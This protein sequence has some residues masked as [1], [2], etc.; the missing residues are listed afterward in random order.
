M[1][2]DPSNPVTKLN[3]AALR[4]NVAAY[5]NIQTQGYNTAADSGGG[6]YYLNTTDTTSGDNGGTII[7]DAAGHRYYRVLTGSIS[8]LAFTTATVLTNANLGQLIG[9]AGA[10]SYANTLP[11][12]TTC[13]P[14]STLAL[15]SSVAGVIFNVTSPDVIHPCTPAT[16]TSITLNVG[17]TAML[18]VTAA[19]IWQLVG[20][21]VQLPFTGV[22]NG[23]APLNSPHF[24]GIPTAPTAAPGDTTTQIAT[25]A[26]VA[27]SFAPIAS[28]TLTGIPRAP[29]ASQG[30]TTTQIATTAFVTTSPQFLG[31]PT[32]PTAAV[33]TQTTQLATTAFAN[34]GSSLGASG[35]QIFPSGMIIQWGIVPSGSAR[36][37]TFPMTFPNAAYSITSGNNATIT[38]NAV[39]FNNLTTTGVDVTSTIEN[40]YFMVIGS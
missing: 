5:Q 37:I 27:A 10:G 20:G 38:S 33:G 31:T 22:F 29:T 6:F 40:D 1:A 14:G 35:Y 7:V 17:D 15:F 12:T 28:P 30:T 24:T 23:F 8:Q 19:G 34:P 4:A 32:A 11:L 2:F 9:F 3:I 25:D 13:P 36:T 16:L 39:S 21:S 18:E 26:F